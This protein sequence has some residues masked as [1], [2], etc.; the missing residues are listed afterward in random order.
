MLAP[1][2]LTPRLRLRARTLDDVEANLAMDMDPA[3]QRH[4]PNLHGRSPEAHRKELTDRI[5]DGWPQ[6][7]ALWVVE[8]RDPQAADG[9]AGFVGW[10]ALF[11][12]QESGLIEIGYR[13]LP[14]TWGQGVA[15]EAATVVL[16][17]GF[18]VLELDSIVAVTHPDNRG[19]Q[20][21]LTKIG[22][23]PQGLRFH[24]GLDL[25]Y[26]SLDRSA[27]LSAAS[28][29]NVAGDLD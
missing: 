25:S 27:Y 7:G 9:P 10:C 24:Y 28:D 22:L 17:L 1:T 2:L 18:R 4:L 26:F 20:A 3:V 5:L 21:V 12:L 14:S 6:I 13:Y 29:G 23:R 11:P 8:W 15:T 16:D 19:S